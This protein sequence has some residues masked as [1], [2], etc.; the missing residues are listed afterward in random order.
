MAVLGFEP[1]W[2]G[3]VTTALKRNVAELPCLRAPGL[4][5]APLPL[6]IPVWFSGQDMEIMVWPTF[7]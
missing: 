3:W 5:A 2:L 4:S 6:I 7:L 1:K